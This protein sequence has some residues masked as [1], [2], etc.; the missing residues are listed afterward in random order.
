M[1]IV[2]DVRSEADFAKWSEEQQKLLAASADDPNKEWTQAELVA[3]GEK[4]YQ[5]CAACHQGSGKGV[6]G[7]FPA[8]DGSKVVM[9][10]KADQITVLLK[11]RQGT[12][13]QS[14]ANQLSDVEIAAVIT[15]TRNSWGNAGKGQDP[16]VAPA[17]IKAAR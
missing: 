5:T 11:G 7:A 9:G 2:V 10:P 8:L 14:F 12:A 3:R 1:P 6:M 4:V 16:V 17:D 15:Y 13:M